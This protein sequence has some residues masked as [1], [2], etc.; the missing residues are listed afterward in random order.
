MKAF[1]PHENSSSLQRPLLTC[2]HVKVNKGGQK[3]KNPVFVE[4]RWGGGAKPANESQREEEGTGRGNT[5]AS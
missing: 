3:M 4:G 2:C 5:G 1:Y